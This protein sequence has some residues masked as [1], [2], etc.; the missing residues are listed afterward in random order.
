MQLN[1]QEYIPNQHHSPI[2]E[3]QNHSFQGNTLIRKTK[4]PFWG[5][6]LSCGGPLFL[7]LAL[8]LFGFRLYLQENNK[9]TLTFLPQQETN[10]TLISTA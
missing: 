3:L 6:F 10:L 4:Y 1:S 2:H 5:F 8:V 9:P 7:I